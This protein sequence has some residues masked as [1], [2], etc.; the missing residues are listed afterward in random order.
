VRRD[1]RA[2]ARLRGD[3]PPRRPG[4]DAWLA[5]GARPLGPEAALNI[6]AVI[7]NYGTPDYTIRSV[8]ALT[9]DGLAPERIVVVENGSQ[10]DSLDRLRE[11]IPDS[12]LLPLEENVGFARASNLGARHL[13]GDAYLFVNSDAFVHRPGSIDALRRALGDPAV[14]I[15]VPRFLNED[16]T[17]QPKVVPLSSPSVALVRASGLS[18]FVPNRWQPRWS[19]HWD[20]SE[21]REIQAASGVVFLVRD[22]LWDEVGGFEEG[23][24]M[25]AEDLDLCWHARNRGW[26]VWFVGDS[27]FV[28]IGA[29][30]TAKHWDSPERAERIGR[31]EA[32]MIRRHLRGAR[33]GLTLGLIRAGVAGRL[34]FY[35]ATRN[36]EAAAAMRGSLRGYSA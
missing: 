33:G 10:D 29:G 15:A 23:H 9:G 6:T 24:L 13:P 4:G 14:G 11:A 32:A 22:K 30:A 25:Y 27:E 2:L 12:V 35:K 34:A 3:R 8:R 20:H 26:K 21:S 1:R 5:E 7:A 31:A 18:R 36:R 16:L 28:H 19:T 17:L